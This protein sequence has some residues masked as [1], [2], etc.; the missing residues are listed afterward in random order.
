MLG[1]KFVNHVQDNTSAPSSPRGLYGH[2]LLNEAL[3]SEALMRGLS[4][5]TQ[6]PFS[7]GDSSTKSFSRE[8]IKA[9]E[10]PF[11]QNISMLPVT[12]RSPYSGTILRHTPIGQARQSRLLRQK[13]ENLAVLDLKSAKRNVITVCVPWNPQKGIK[14]T[15]QPLKS[16]TAFA[17]VIHH[18]NNKQ[19]ERI[20]RVEI[21]DSATYLDLKKMLYEQAGLG[22]KLPSSSKLSRDLHSDFHFVDSQNEQLPVSTVPV[23]YDQAKG[24]ELKKVGGAEVAKSI[25]ILRDYFDG[26]SAQEKAECNAKTLYP[27]LVN[28]KAKP[29]CLDESGNLIIPVYNAAHFATHQICRALD[30]DHATLGTNYVEK[31][32]NGTSVYDNQDW[33]Q[34]E[35]LSDFTKPL[36]HAITEGFLDKFQIISQYAHHFSD[37]RLALCYASIVD[38]SY[39]APRSLMAE[40]ITEKALKPYIMANAQLPDYLTYAVAKI[41]AAMIHCK[42][43]YTTF[44]ERCESTLAPLKNPEL[45]Y[46]NSSN[47]N[48]SDRTMQAYSRFVKLPKDIVAAGQSL[49]KTDIGK[50]KTKKKQTIQH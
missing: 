29:V 38:D 47:T 1:T 30:Y 24:S 8:T 15:K 19:E 5:M 16:F 7:P 32:F 39:N 40:A 25:N 13:I 26:L 17:H 31:T 41:R 27:L 42:S 14:N 45:S 46:D 11:K 37:E 28:K 6:N 18:L 10:A 43:N 44:D 12:N 34:I 2:S 50:K 3:C 36:S 4:L 33:N 22:A 48:I 23:N 21:P 9:P 49:E 20:I 35:Y